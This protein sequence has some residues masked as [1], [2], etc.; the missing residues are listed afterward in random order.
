M[1]KFN[2]L[3]DCQAGF[4]KGYSTTDNLF[5]INS[6][7]E[8]FKSKREKLF[9]VFVHFKQEFDTVWRDGIWQKLKTHY[10]NGKCYNLIKNLYNNIKSRITTSEGS[11]V[12]FPCSTGVRQVES[13]SPFLFSI[14]LNDL[15][16]YLSQKRVSG[17]TCDFN[18]DA[19]PIYFKLFILLYADDTVIF[20]DS[21]E[22]FKK[23]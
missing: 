13:L 2:V 4:R 6:L 3:F 16:Y 9:L 22:N 1:Q 18:G 11:S 17:I 23:H 12:F 14:Y 15:E 10:I 21:A 5:I 20:G 8:I 19:I 7:I